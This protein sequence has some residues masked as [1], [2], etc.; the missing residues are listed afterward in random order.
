M[1][2]SPNAIPEHTLASVARAIE[3]QEDLEKN[4]G[5]K[6]AQLGR[7]YYFQ[8][9]VQEGLERWGDAVESLK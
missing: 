6:S 5:K 9:T 4:S 2:L 8:A 1:M 3:I 7:Y